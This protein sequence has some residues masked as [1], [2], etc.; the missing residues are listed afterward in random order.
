MYLQNFEIQ[1]PEL[2]LLLTNFGVEPPKALR[3]PNHHKSA[4]GVT[5]RILA[6]VAQTR[7]NEKSARDFRV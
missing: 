7:G 1:S 4:G 3:S 6:V 5:S 2:A